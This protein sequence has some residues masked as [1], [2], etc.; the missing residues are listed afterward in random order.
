MDQNG[1]HDVITEVLDSASPG[2]SAKA[3]QATLERLLEERGTLSAGAMLKSTG[4]CAVPITR[5]GHRSLL[6][7]RIQSIAMSEHQA[8]YLRT[9]GSIAPP[10]N[11]KTFD[12]QKKA[13][14]PVYDERDPD[15]IKASTEAYMDYTKLVVLH[16]L[17][18]DLVDAQGALVWSRSGAPRN[19]DQALSV[20]ESFGF[21]VSQMNLI[22]DA[23]EALTTEDAQQEAKT[24]TA[25]F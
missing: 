13:Y 23:I 8:L 24:E 20:L 25:N 10:T 11:K 4:I 16:G 2:E 17:D 9:V 21:S 5:N 6:P 15:Y 22:K 19:E 7:L 1:T 12:I 14:V 18:E 3:H